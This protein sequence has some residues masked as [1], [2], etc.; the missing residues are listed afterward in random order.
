MKLSI[1]LSTQPASFAALAYKGQLRDNLAKIQALGYDGVELAVR[2]PALLDEEEVRR[3]LNDFAL[4]VPAIGTG[5]AYGEEG[6]SLTHSNPEK[7]RMAI[8][9]IQSQIRF[10]SLW[11]AKVIIG[12]IRGKSEAGAA[13]D[14]MESMLLEALRECAGESREVS[15]AIEPINR[16]E[17]DL[18]NTV[19]SALRFLEKLS[20]DQVG[21]LLDTFHM[22]IEEPSL[23]ESIRMAKDCLFHFHLADSNRW[24]PG[25]GHVDFK[26][27]VETLDQVGYRG[28][29]SAEILPF[30]DSDTAAEKTLQHMG[31]LLGRVPGPKP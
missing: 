10:A 31:S 17:T 20:L 30:P 19:S 13:K 25:A 6:L 16:Y 27:V 14:R 22:N 18:L 2:D 11:N 21:L 15:L 8:E 3:M 1:V 26:S 5:Q 24:Y 9:R 4:P 12:L 7:R 28:W 23:L 29:L